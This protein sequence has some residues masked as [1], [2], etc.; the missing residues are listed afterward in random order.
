MT[1]LSPRQSQPPL[2]EIS[3]EPR[4][5]LPICL[6]LRRA[7]CAN[8]CRR[9]RRFEFHF[10]HV[11]ACRRDLWFF[12]GRLHC[13]AAHL[14]D[15]TGKNPHR[16]RIQEN[17]HRFARLHLGDIAFID[18]HQ[19]REFLRVADRA[20]DRARLEPGASISRVER[21]TRPRGKPLRSRFLLLI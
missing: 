4:E 20:D 5:R 16:C 9:I 3:G 8:E 11:P 2:H 10:H 17:A 12:L 6:D 18:G 7:A 19:R 14:L 21:R 15:G 13:P 1:C